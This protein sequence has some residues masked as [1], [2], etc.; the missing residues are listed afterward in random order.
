[1][2]KLIL[3][4]IL[5]ASFVIP[6]FAARAKTMRASITRAVIATVLASVLWLVAVMYLYPNVLKL[7]H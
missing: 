7:Q 3:I 6:F 5:V 4:S 1:M 2:E